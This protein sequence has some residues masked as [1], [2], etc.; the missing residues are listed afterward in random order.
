VADFITAPLAVRHRVWPRAIARLADQPWVA[1]LVAHHAITVYDRFRAD[2]AWDTFFARMEESRAEML[3]ASSLPLDDLCSD[4]VFVRLGDLISLA[5]CTGTSDI[6]RFDEWAVQLAG[7]R[8][9][10]TPDAFGGETVPVEISAREM[11][12]RTFASDEDL[13]GALSLAS[14]RIL[15]GE[16]V[17]TPPRPQETRAL[18]SGS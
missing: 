7:P 13:R 14:T 9:V 4:Y 6:L 5:F 3:E 12:T 18:V 16:V 17:S 10:V 11:P 8:V 15:R 2:R 1:G